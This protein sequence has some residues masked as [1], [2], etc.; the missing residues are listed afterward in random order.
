MTGRVLSILAGGLIAGVSFAAPITGDS[1]TFTGLQ[2][3]EQV[4]TYYDGGFGGSGSGPGPSFGVSFSNGLVADSTVIAFGPS[5]L[6]EA[7]VTMNLDNP[8]SQIL[9][10]Y[11]AG[12]GT[13]SFY[14][15]TDATG[16]LLASIPLVSQ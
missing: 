9:S 16:T 13:I 1:L 10:F 2:N 8:W 4:L 14:S 6:V 12:T 7:P 3:G 15:G 11:Y 5:A